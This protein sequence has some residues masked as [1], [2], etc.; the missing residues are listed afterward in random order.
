[1]LE[2]ISPDV[3]AAIIAGSA[4][5]FASVVALIV[6]RYFQTKREQL[7]AHREKKAE[8]Y[9]EFLIQIFDLFA[10]AKKNEEYTKDLTAVLR[11]IQRKLI[12]WAG[13][14]VIIAYYDWHKALTTKPPRAIQM[15]KLLDF[16]LAL[17]ED[18]GHSNSRIQR[19]HFARVLLKNPEWFIQEFNKN[20]NITLEE[21]I[22]LEKKLEPINNK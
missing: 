14:N 13:P 20:P 18:L 21:I 5:I 12:L 19:K 6:S 3:I 16:F 2:N 7:I 8:L 4:T 22:K 17:R 15:I 1:V 9:N 11:E 10:S